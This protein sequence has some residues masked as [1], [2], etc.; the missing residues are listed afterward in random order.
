MFIKQITALLA[1]LAIGWSAALAAAPAPNG[2]SGNRVL[3]IDPSSMRMGTAKATL[4]IG[5]LQRV[6]GLYTGDYKVKVF[7]YF[8]KNEKGR[9]AIVVSDESLAQA[10]RGKVVAIT[11]TATTSGKGGKSRRIDATATPTDSNRGVLKLWFLAGKQKMFFEPDY[12]FA[13]FAGNEPTLVRAR[14]A[15]TKF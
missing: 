7:P 1:L 2:D 5:A 10:N 9:L 14:P 11:G 3:L 13:D 12:H 4:T 8:F 15:E 6:N